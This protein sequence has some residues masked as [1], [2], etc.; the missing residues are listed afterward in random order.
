VLWGDR[1]QVAG[2]DYRRASAADIPSARFQLL[3]AT[4]HV[5]GGRGGQQGGD[6]VVIRVNSSV[7]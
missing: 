1:D 5:L 2:R 3:P 7:T 4:G 6:R